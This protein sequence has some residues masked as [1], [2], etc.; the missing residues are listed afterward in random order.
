MTRAVLRN[1]EDQTPAVPAP[2]DGVPVPAAE[3]RTG[4]I[5]LI[6]GREASVVAVDWVPFHDEK[7][8]GQ[9]VPGIAIHWN[10][11]QSRGILRRRPD[12]RLHRA[13]APDMAALERDWPDWQVWTVRKYIGG[14]AWCARRRD[15]HRRVLTAGS[16]DELA[17]Y[18]EETTQG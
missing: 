16:A 11:P 13:A 12:D 2:P 15:D 7:A 6:D 3:V 17:A 9:L 1:G 4:D 10:A 18:L 5:L 8:G 14:T